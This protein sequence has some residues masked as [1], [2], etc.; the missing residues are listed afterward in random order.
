NKIAISSAYVGVQ[1]S[2]YPVNVIHLWTSGPEEGVLKVKFIRGAGV[3][4]D[5]FREK[6]RQEVAKKLP[7][8]R[9]SFEPAD[10]VDQVMSQG[11]NTPIEI[12]ILGKNLA[13]DREFAK[14]VLARLQQ[15]PYLRDL[16]YG[17]PQ[18]YP[19]MKI[20]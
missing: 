14:N 20:D 11:S 1:A 10:L 17:A 2:S 12:R 19:A 4:I 15:L 18:G 16:S 8:V 9:L 3:R 5:L 13:Q 7:G 6:L